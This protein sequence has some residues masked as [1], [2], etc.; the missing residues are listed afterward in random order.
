MA[1]SPDNHAINMEYLNKLHAKYPGHASLLIAFLDDC[2]RAGFGWSYT[3]EK[4][5][6]AVKETVVIV[7]VGSADAWFSFGIS[8]N[9]NVQMLWGKSSKC[10]DGELSQ[11][12]CTAVSAVIPGTEPYNSGKF[13]N[14][15]I[16]PKKPGT[17]VYFRLDQFLDGAPA[18]LAA[19]KNLRTKL[20]GL[21]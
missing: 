18:I 6:P 14:V 12:F 7:R 21:P 15:Q 1:K 19:M 9:G 17:S 20:S 2:A 11:D 10:L 3:Q 16:R 4:D 8:E 5:Q 13:W